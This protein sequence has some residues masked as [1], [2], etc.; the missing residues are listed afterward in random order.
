[1]IT[2]A[3]EAVN[4]TKVYQLKGNRKEIR[5]LD[6]LNLSIKKGELFGL[7][8]PNG[9]GKTTFVRILTTSLAP[10]SGDVYI[11]GFNINTQIKQAKSRIAIMLGGSMNYGSLSGYNNLKFYAK[12]YKIKNYRQKIEELAEKIGLNEWLNQ[13]V[14]KYSS[15]MLVKLAVCRTLLIDRPF[16]FLDEPMRGLDVKTKDFLI[17]ILKNSGKTILLTS[18]DMDVIEKVC[19]KIAFI[20]NGTIIK[21]GTPE[22]IKIFKHSEIQ[23]EA[24]VEKNIEQLLLELKDLDYVKN[25]E[26]NL[27]SIKITIEN[28]NY[29]NDIISILTKYKISIFNEKVA[30]LE[31]SFRKIVS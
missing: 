27:K 6:N 26:H 9:A 11:D 7:L 5:A 23:I 1:M 13:Y 3:I 22:D 15:G 25:F 29:Y 12:I 2:P 19:N 18:H 4:L 10:T 21:F 16:L 24:V 8:G 31:E 14:Y 17:N 30:T 20:K 28:R